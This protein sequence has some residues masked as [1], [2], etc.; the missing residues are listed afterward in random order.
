MSTNASP[1]EAKPVDV[2]RLFIRVCRRFVVAREDGYGNE[3]RLGLEICL[4]SGKASIRVHYSVIF[5]CHSG[6]N[7]ILLTD[8]K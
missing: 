6:L 2:L 4:E 3:E 7:V 8:P 5:S 1:V